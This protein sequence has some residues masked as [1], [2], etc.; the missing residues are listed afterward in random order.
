MA[1]M[2][3]RRVQ[4]RGHVVQLLTGTHEDTIQHAA[5]DGLT[6]TAVPSFDP[7]V[8]QKIREW[9]PEIL[10]VIDAVDPSFPHA[11]LTMAQAWKLPLMITPASAIET[12]QDS[13]ATM[14][15]CRA[16][17]RVFVL[18]NA[19]AERFR[20]CGVDAKKL[21]VTGQ[22][23]HLEGTPDPAG[24]RRRYSITGPLVL[25]LGRKVSFKG[26]QILLEATRHTWAQRDDSMFMFVGPRWDSDC[27][28]QFRTFADPRIIELEMVEE[29]EKYSALTACDVLCLPTTIDVFPLVFVEAWACGK[30]V[31]TATFPGAA[32]VIHD[33]EDGLIV[34][35]E[36]VAL[37]DAI[38]ALLN[39]PERRLALGEAGRARVKRELNW[40]AVVDCIV[41]AYYQNLG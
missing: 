9:Q 19:E 41:E 38:V 28:E 16:A 40:D 21:V 30:P 27:G 29:Q 36:P 6:V 10:H 22:G 5:F 17:E 11:A 14:A 37:A 23:S 3:A 24:F 4:Q 26:Y 7:P 12:W 31:I 8:L 34:K 13:T 2:I 25:F 35:P 18:T 1:R 39:D 33:G 32:E 15:V 20:R